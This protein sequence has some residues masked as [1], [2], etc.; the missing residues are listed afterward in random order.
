[1][2]SGRSVPQCKVAVAAAV[3]GLPNR[4]KQVHMLSV[5]NSVRLFALV[6]ALAYPHAAARAQQPVFD[7]KANYVKRD[8]MV[9]MRDGVKLF[10]I[11][12]TPRDTT[13]TY[14]IMLFRTPYSIRPYEPDAYRA[15]LGPSAEFDRDGYIFVFQDVRGKFRSEGEFEVMKPFRRSE[16]HT[17]ELQSRLHLVCRLL[18]EKK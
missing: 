13:R 3:V 14:P 8:Y 12:Y 5:R 6:V 18:L 1:M 17:S 7:V 16:E 11:I 15:V 10:T 2:E 4:R 9:P